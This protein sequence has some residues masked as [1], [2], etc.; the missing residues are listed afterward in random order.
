MSYAN[1]G[2]TGTAD[3]LTRLRLFDP[4][5]FSFIRVYRT[6]FAYFPLLPLLNFFLFPFFFFISCFFP[7]YF[8]SF[9]CSL[10]YYLVCHLGQQPC[11]VACTELTINNKIRTPQVV[12]IVGL[13]WASNDTT[14]DLKN[15]HLAVCAL[16]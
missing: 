11:V 14:F 5:P 12:L 15:L 16:P 1:L 8:F 7:T 3:H 9:P 6:L 4:L 2:A 13:S 10:V